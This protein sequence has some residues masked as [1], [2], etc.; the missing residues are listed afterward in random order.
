[1]PEENVE[2]IKRLELLKDVIDEKISQLEIEDVNEFIP[3]QYH[4]EGMLA[5]V[6]IRH[7][8]FPDAVETIHLQI[9]K[10]TALNEDGNKYTEPA[11]GDEFPEPLNF[12]IEPTI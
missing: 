12:Q 10:P 2:L 5:I 7:R 11:K 9:G 8:S 6:Q 1:M 3:N 4:L